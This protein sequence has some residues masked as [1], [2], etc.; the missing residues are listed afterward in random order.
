MNYEETLIY[1]QNLNIAKGIRP[2]L[3][4]VRDLCSAMGSPEQELKFIHVAGT[5]GKGSV[6]GYIL[7]ILK[8]AGL[9]VGLYRSPAVFDEREI[10]SING[11]NISKKDYVNLIERISA[12]NLPYTR[13]EI[14]TVSAFLYFKEKECDL[15][16]LECGMGGELDATNVVNNT[17]VAVFTAIGMDHMSYLGNSLTQIAATKGGIIK[18]GCEVVADGSNKKEVLD[19]LC[20][21]AGACGA[22][23]YV[24]EPD[25]IKKLSMKSS[26]T[27]FDYKELKAVKLSVLGKNQSENAALAIEAVKALERKNIAIKSSSYLKGLEKMTLPGRFEIIS[28]KPIFVIDGAHN[29]PASARLRENLEYY[30]SKKKIIFIMCVLK[31]KEYDKVIENTADLAWQIITVTSPNRGRG[32][33]ALDLANAVSEYNPNVTASDSIEE[34]VELAL[35]LADKD[36]AVISFGSLSHL[37]QVKKV[38]ENKN[39]IKKDWHGTR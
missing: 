24:S 16:V 9:K 35:M 11:R 10:I 25:K 32:L 4:R 1:L 15:V 13:F 6:S 18:P 31:D 28:A 38:V 39:D 21:R 26:G 3:S 27:T 36:T 12:T 34:A 17:L 14:E 2:G 30:F 22:G 8:A 19:E 7:E 29:E 33:A 5:N 37:K 23:F 20:K